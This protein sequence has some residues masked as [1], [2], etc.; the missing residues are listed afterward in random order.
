MI[1]ELPRGPKFPGRY[2]IGNSQFGGDGI[3]PSQLYCV[4]LRFKVPS[5]LCECTKIV[6]EAG[7]VDLQYDLFAVW[8][9]TAAERRTTRT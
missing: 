3:E 9:A 5:P 8:I 6:H 2:D 7:V 1:F 4:C